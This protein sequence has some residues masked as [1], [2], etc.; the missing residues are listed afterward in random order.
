VTTVRDFTQVFD[1]YAQFEES[2]INSKMEQMAG[3]SAE[4]SEN[5]ENKVFC[6][7][8]SYC[9]VTAVMKL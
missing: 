3:D 7:C 2:V 1:A 5:G 9:C 6:G 4:H 8:F